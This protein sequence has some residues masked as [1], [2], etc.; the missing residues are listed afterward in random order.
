[1]RALDLDLEFPAR[2]SSIQFNHA[3][4]CPLPARAA[5]ALGAYAENLTTRGGLDWKDW[6]RK[7]DE[8]RALAARLI[9]ASDTAG[10]ASSISIVPNTSYGLG[11]VAG[12]F[13]FAAGDSV[14]TTASEFPANLAPWAAL[15]AKGVDVRRVPTRDGAFTASDV[16]A[17]CDATTRLVSVSLVA[18]H[19]GFRAPAEELAALCRERGIV[20]GLDAIQ[21]VGAQRVDVA[22]WGVDFLSA[23]G[24]KWMLG[25]EGAGIL[26]TSPALRER[27]AP[28]PGW[29]NLDRATPTDYRVPEV[30]RYRADGARFEPGALPTPGLYALAASLGLLLEIGLPEVEARIARTLA[31]LVDGLPRLG[32]EP[33]LF[34]GPPRSGILAARPPAGKDARYY[35]KRAAEENVVISAREGFVRFSP[36]V[37]NDESEAERVLALLKRL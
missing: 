17:A 1:D 31:V 5:A 9:G 11:I 30:L 22:G 18:F 27:L 7:A 26:F 3:A 13:P 15:A 25:P 6:I 35:Q 4:V 34:G 8:V 29:T 28:P 12:G 24:H 20:F 14:V 10:G 33:V 16:E 37:G 19:T 32:F 21:A 2:R 23:D 36:H